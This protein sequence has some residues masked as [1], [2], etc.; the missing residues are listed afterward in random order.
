LPAAACCPTCSSARA[1]IGRKRVATLMKKMGIEALYKKP[2]TSR[3]HP[4][5]PVYPYLLRNLEVHRP[6][7]VFAA[8]I[9]PNEVKF[10]SNQTGPPLIPQCS[11]AFCLPLNRLFARI[12]FCRMS[13]AVAVRMNGFGL[14]LWRTT[15]ADAATG[16]RS[17]LRVA[18][19]GGKHAP[20]PLFM[21]MGGTR[22]VTGVSNVPCRFQACASTPPRR[23]HPR[24]HPARITASPPVCLPSHRHASM[25]HRG[26]ARQG[27]SVQPQSRQSS[28]NP[29]ALY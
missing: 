11:V 26:L 7:Q 21:S 2:N 14:A 16:A 1:M 22:E 9:T 25:A 13:R 4:P 24:S 20:I 10:V 6:N 12:T 3:R 8:D 15:Y 19:S 5:H 29:P 17:A 27:P 23:L 28:P 18:L